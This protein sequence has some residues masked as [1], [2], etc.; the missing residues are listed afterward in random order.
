MNCK[1]VVVT[2]A[3]TILVISTIVMMGLKKWDRPAELRVICNSDADKTDQTVIQWGYYQC[4]VT[5]SEWYLYGPFLGMLSFVLAG[6]M[7]G[8][9]HTFRHSAAERLIL[10]TWS[11]VFVV[12]SMHFLI[13]VLSGAIWLNYL[14]TITIIALLPGVLLACYVASIYRADKVSSIESSQPPPPSQPTS[15]LASLE[16]QGPTTTVRGDRSSLSSPE[17]QTTESKR[18]M[19]DEEKAETALSTV[20]LGDGGLSSSSNKDTDEVEQE[21]HTDDNNNNNS[22]PYYTSKSMST[23]THMLPQER[24][25]GSLLIAPI[26]YQVALVALFLLAINHMIELRYMYPHGRV[27]D[28]ERGKQQMGASMFGI[29]IAILASLIHVF[30]ITCTPKS[31]RP[32]VAAIEKYQY[33]LDALAITYTSAILLA[34]ACYPS[35]VADE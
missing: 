28:N 34:L 33:R 19:G 4:V 2:A 9:I 20:V 5:N 24:D 23:E 35:S 3:Y 29:V 14:I 17:S 16:F 7:A 30:V 27:L 12:S 26:L 22:L 18:E 8:R 1:L 10:R 31:T 6:A 25:H 15:E 11:D 13:S 21:E 32:T